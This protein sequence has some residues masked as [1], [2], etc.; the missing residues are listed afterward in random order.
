MRTKFQLGDLVYL[1]TDYDQ[2]ERFITGILYR[3]SGV[4]YYVSQST[5]E[6]TH[7]EF[8]MSSKKDMLLFMGSSTN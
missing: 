3:P 4:I 8:E 1:K 5:I 6:S 7:F 2:L